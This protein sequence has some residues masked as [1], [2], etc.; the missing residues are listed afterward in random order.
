MVTQSPFS[1]RPCCYPDFFSLHNFNFSSFSFCVTFNSEGIYFSIENISAWKSRTLWLL[2]ILTLEETSN[3]AESSILKFNN[4][5]AV[6]ISFRY[7]QEYGIPWNPQHWERAPLAAD[8][9]VQWWD[10]SLEHTCESSFPFS[11]LLN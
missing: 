1:F 5:F 8:D 11:R 9:W 7:I 2:L 10:A 4:D 3:D 6:G